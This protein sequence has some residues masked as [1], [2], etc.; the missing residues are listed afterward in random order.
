MAMRYRVLAVLLGAAASTSASASIL[1]IGNSLARMCYEAA[2]SEVRP[3]IEVVRRCDTA[4]REEA[5][6]RFDRMATHVNR[7]ILHLRRGDPT[8]AISDFDRA[9]ELDPTQP[10]PYFNKGAAMVRL[11]N[12]QAALELFTMALERNPDRPELAHFGRGIAYE[13]LGNVRAAYRDYRRASQLD[14]EWE[15]PRAELA[16]FRV[17]RQGD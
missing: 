1:T 7:G 2:D 6:Q 5:L 9:I 12:P 8:L 4:L 13:N 3:G 17:V 10:E 16:R 11:Q 14:P 15:E